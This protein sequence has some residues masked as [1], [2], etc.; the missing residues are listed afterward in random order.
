[1]AAS[2][3]LSR[4]W[5]RRCLSPS[6]PMVHVTSI[7]KRAFSKNFPSWNSSV[8][9]LVRGHRPDSAVSTMGSLCRASSST[10][11]SNSPLPGAQSIVIHTR[12]AAVAV[13]PTLLWKN[14]Y[15]HGSQQCYNHSHCRYFS[16]SA[17]AIADHDVAMEFDDPIRREEE[18]AEVHKRRKLSDVRV[19]TDCQMIGEWFHLYVTL[20]C[21]GLFFLPN[22]GPHSRSLGRQA[23]VPLGRSRHTKRCHCQRSHSNHH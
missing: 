19:V 10:I 3:H 18:Q 11:S 15:T 2:P 21:F 22:S 13:A 5:S 9:C 7:S 14:F 4:L 1:M 8:S 16:S 23:L 12:S 17:T 6:G 20:T